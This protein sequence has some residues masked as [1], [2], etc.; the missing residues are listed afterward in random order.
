MH[1]ILTSTDVVKDISIYLCKYIYTGHGVVDYTR[2][3]LSF[4]FLFWLF[5]GLSAYIF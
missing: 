5:G 2:F 4:F 1:K 3:D